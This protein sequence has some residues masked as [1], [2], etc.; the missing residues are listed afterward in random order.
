MA[1]QPVR[2]DILNS[3]VALEEAVLALRALAAELPRITGNGV[4]D[5]L[6]AVGM[7]V[8][9]G[10]EVEAD[11]LL[12]RLVAG[13]E[14][15]LRLKSQGALF[16]RGFPEE[17][18]MARHL[19]DSVEALEEGLGGAFF[20]LAEE[21]DADMLKQAMCTLASGGTA[22]VAALAAMKEVSWADHRFSEDP[23]LEELFRAVEAADD[24][25]VEVAL[26]ALDDAHE[27]MGT[28]LA[29]LL[30][31]FAPEGWRAR[32][33]S[34]L[35]EHWGRLTAARESLHQAHQQAN[36]SVEQLLAFQYLANH[37]DE[38]E[39]EAAESLPTRAGL[40]EVAHLVGLVELMGAVFEERA[41]LALLEDELTRMVA[42]YRE[43]QEQLEKVYEG[44]NL[45]GDNPELERLLEVSEQLGEGLTLLET[46][47]EARN[48][49]LFPEIWEILEEPAR[50][51]H[52][53]AA[54]QQLEGFSA[55]PDAPLPPFFA[56]LRTLWR[57]RLSRR[58]GAGEFM[59][60][61]AKANKEID[62]LAIQLRG[63]VREGSQEAEALD[64]LIA[65]LTTL[66][67]RALT[68]PQDAD[69]ETIE[70]L[71]QE[72]ERRSALLR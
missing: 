4:L 11:A 20:Y 53:L 27:V 48:V 70:D 69:L 35:R 14:A 37:F 58:L 47:L 23:V 9:R 3:A 54:S 1:A 12:S 10:A 26:I 19:S 30:G 68:G 52:G 51:L 66:C 50:E 17:E 22:A 32:H 42:S 16:A 7:S 45:S 49:T 56:E 62:G 15:V 71:G 61:L 59:H 33:V 18:E 40:P 25:R 34:A 6:F 8:A 39:N 57:D 44:R 63:G 60:A 67:R 65:E 64:K 43:Y 55:Q 21:Q 38:L 28:E 72:W 46:A 24:E 36:L 31:T 2:Q 13:R 41:P 29:S 5:E